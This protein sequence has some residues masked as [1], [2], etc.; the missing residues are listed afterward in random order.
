[1]K[2]KFVFCSSKEKEEHRVTVIVEASEKPKIDAGDLYIGVYPVERFEVIEEE[3]TQD[4]KN[5]FLIGPSPRNGLSVYGGFPEE[6]FGME[7][8]EII[9]E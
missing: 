7:F 6:K 8:P 3:S 9:E 4:G 5:R 1:M 2:I